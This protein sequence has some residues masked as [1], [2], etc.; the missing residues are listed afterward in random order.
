MAGDYTLPL[1]VTDR[2]RFYDGQFLQD[3]DFIDEQKYH[4]ARRNRHHR[5]LHVTGVAEGL[6]AYAPANTTF[7]VKVRPGLAVDPDGRQ[8]LLT[9]ISPLSS[10]NSTLP[11]EAAGSVRWLYIAYHQVADKLQAS[12]QGVEGETRWSETPYIFASDKS[13]IGRNVNYDGPDWSSYLAEGDGPPPPV[14]LAKLTIDD[15]GNVKVDNSVCQFSGLRLPGP[16]SLAPVLRTDAAGNVGLWLVEDGDLS[17]RLTISPDGS[18]GINTNT[19]SAALEIGTTL[20]ATKNGQALVALNIAPTF[21]AGGKT[22]VKNYGLLVGSG[23]VGIGTTSPG[24]T[25]DVKGNTVVQSYL[26]VGQTSAT[27]YKNVTADSNDLIVNGQFAA[28]GSGGSAIYKL[29]IGYAPPSQGEGTLIVSGN[30][31][32]GTTEPGS[33]L[34]VA[35][36]T[37]I[38]AGQKDVVF[39]QGNFGNKNT[40]D[41][42]FNKGNVGFNQSE[43]ALFNQNDNV[44]ANRYFQLQ[45][46]ADAGGL[47]I[48]KGGNVG[49]GTTEPNGQLEIK[50]SAS[51][52]K[53]KLGGTGGDAHHISSARDLVL[54]SAQNGNNAAFFFRSTTYDDLSKHT[55]LVTIL[56]NGNVGVGTTP[57]SKLDVAGE[58]R[59]LAGQKDVVFSQGNFGNKNTTDLFFN[60]GNVG[61]NQSEFALFN[62]NDNV[63]ANRYFQL[64]YSADAGG[65]TIRKGGNVGIGTT[66]PGGKLHIL[67][68]AQYAGGDT[69]ILGPTDGANLRLGYDS[70]YCWIQSHGKKPLAINSIGNNVGIGTTDPQAPLDVHGR[71]FRMGKEFSYGGSITGGGTVSV[72]WG[73]KSDWMI[74]VSPN[75]MGQEESGSEA[76]NALLKI[77]C[78]AKSDNNTTSWTIIARYKYRTSQS[79]GSWHTDGKANYLLVPL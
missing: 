53:L 56:G 57:G 73:T 3:Q 10:P 9:S 43:F 25:L 41:L 39:S 69:L 16:D 31:G 60:K 42:F 47:T 48:R 22:S 5:T 38:L 76:D 54:N 79:M 44:E 29:G 64:Q 55:D 65:L 32:I 78:Y 59:I 36:E 51:S 49:I 23:N 26:L 75:S 7:Q 62:Q 8:I 74:F 66:T 34:D 72:P 37:R 50:G 77:E 58:T 67:N 28:G 63:E 12:G 17:E 70:D 6:T 33:K 21:D 4:L 40:T 45:Y 52:S 15:K 2:V 24:A 61:H 19:P 11:A 13:D 71:I 27:G 14:L 1:A 20:Q 30:V 46:S 68:V 18:V 35:G